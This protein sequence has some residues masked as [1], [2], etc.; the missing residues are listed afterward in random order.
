MRSRGF[1]A[2]WA[3]LVS[4]T[5]LLA[6]GWERLDSCEFF[7]GSHSD[8]DSVEVRR[9]DKH[10]VFRLYFVDCVE[11]NP[12]SRARRA[13]QAR[14]FG[15]K[16]SESAALRAA[17]LARNFTKDK[18]RNPFTVYTRWQAVDP[19]GDNPAI[20]AFVE[21]ADRKDLST[22]LVKEGLAIIR[23][24]D[25]A[26]SDHP[27][28]RRSDEIS[29]DLRKAEV[30]AR[31]Q[32]RG[33][34]GLVK[35][36][37]DGDGQPEILDATDR[38]ALVSRAGT[39]VKVRGRVARIG[40][41]PDGGMTFINFD[42]RG[43][44]GFVGIVRSK[45]LPRFADR[46]PN[47]LKRALVGK[48]VLLEGMITLYRGVP[49]IELESPLQLRIEQDSGKPATTVP[50]SKLQSA[51]TFDFGNLFRYFLYPPGRFA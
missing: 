26:V 24:G 28:G 2:A 5:L 44:D 3:A 45:F 38:E 37:E 36:S 6:Q 17:Y 31:A 15:V 41:L 19:A 23:H 9:S 8:G 20:R 18:L 10:Y 30:E 51:V 32:K 25:T 40:A 29:S 48:H 43:R 1:L 14:Y 21:T 22:L 49:R 16:A 27:N 50:S 46:F 34:W 42:G 39:T 7:E 12:A 47:G 33:A 13:A 4:Q 35:S 11:K